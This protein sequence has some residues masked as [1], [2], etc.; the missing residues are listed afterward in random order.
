MKNTKTLNRNTRSRIIQD[1]EF[2]SFSSMCLIRNATVWHWRMRTLFHGL[3]TIL[4][5]T[6][7]ILQFVIGVW[8][9]CSMACKQLSHWH[10]PY[11]S[12]SLAYENVVPWPANNSHTDI[13]HTTVCHWRMRTLFHGL[14]TTLTLT[15]PI[16]QFVIGVWELRSMACKQFSHWHPP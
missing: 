2:Y 9:R 3:Q 5:L 11:Y 7:P 13:P 10:P 6:S 14:Q 15:S 8:E 1:P 12:L 4:T 16:L